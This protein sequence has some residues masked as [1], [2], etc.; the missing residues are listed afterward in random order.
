MANRYN[1]R[2]FHKDRS[3]TSLDSPDFE[4]IVSVEDLVGSYFSTQDPARLRSPKITYKW[5][6]LVTLM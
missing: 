4:W 1:E 6:N 5:E 2:N 3:L